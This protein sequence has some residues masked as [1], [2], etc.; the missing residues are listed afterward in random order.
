MKKIISRAVSALLCAVISLNPLSVYGAVQIS[1]NTVTTVGSSQTIEQLTANDTYKV[2]DAIY[3]LT[4]SSVNRAASEHFQIIWGNSD[5]TGLVNDELIRG[6]LINLENIRTFYM[7]DLGMKD[8]G[9]SQ[10]SSITGKYKTNIYISNT[11]LSS[12]DDDWAYMSTDADSFAYLFLA[13]GAMRVDEPSWVVPHELAHAFTYH[14]GGIIPYAWYESTA[15]WFRDQ[16]LG[17]QYYAY[18]GNTYGPT[19]DF[20]APYMI[21]SCYYVPHML[22]WYDTWPIFLYISE[23]PDNIDGLGMELMHKIFENTQSD[24]TM[25]ATIE[26]LS[27]VDIKT[28]LGGMARRMATLDFSRQEHYLKHLNEETLTV[29]GNYE[30]IYSALGTPDSQGYQTVAE[31]KFPMQTGFNIIPLE[32][33][34]TKDIL[35]A[36]FIN[37][38]TASGADFRVSL[39]TKTADNTTRYSQMYDS[40]T[41]GI[42]LQGDE[43]QAYLVVCATP[44]NLKNYEINWDSSAED[45]DTRYT[46]KVKIT[47]EDIPVEESSTE[48]TTE[49]TEP[50]TSVPVVTGER[51]HN[52][53]DNGTT[54]DYFTITGNTSNSKGSCT[55]SDRTYNTCLKMESATS[56]SFNASGQGTLTLVFGGNT[57]FSG[58]KVKV[59]GAAYTIDSTGVLNVSLS[60]GSHTITKGDAINLY[61]ISYSEEGTAVEGTTQP[62]TQSTTEAVTESATESST[63]P[64]DS[65]V[66]GDVNLDGKVDDTDS[67]LVLKHIGGSLL[68]TDETALVNADYDCNGVID[69]TDSILILQNKTPEEQIPVTTITTPLEAGTYDAST[70]ISDNARFVVNGST[71]A[72]QIKIDENGYVE[73]LVNDGATV[74]V[75]FKCGSSNTT[76]SA[77]IT[78][79][80]QTSQTVYGGSSEFS[81]LTADLDGGYYRIFAGQTGGTTAQIVQITVNYN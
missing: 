7:E 13:P 75:S 69:I 23:N 51:S 35:K 34:L 9:I 80:D 15:N 62:T 76:K 50:T 11:G 4:D 10:N 49:Y 41:G 73:F 66:S 24:E 78:L 31:D 72:T 59:D 60:A 17:S 19:S 42:Y 43:V 77:Y 58:K 3:S 54:S 48:A 65:P 28:I 18:G 39:V 27:G 67:T 32:A 81:T 25:Y 33:D 36:E 29:E 5:S 2:R 14:Q 63:L 71:S 22:N 44:D 1:V 38:S 37:T 20:F 79:Y 61:Y 57:A 52:F 26:R 47:S 56:I 30:K 6:N 55:Y 16:Y 45:T 64:T 68:I 74:T 21:N 40:G 8:I 12:F 46:Y 70:I 53:E